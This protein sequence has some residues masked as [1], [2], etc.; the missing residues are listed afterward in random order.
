M[1]QRGFLGALRLP[2]RHGE[3]NGH[4]HE[5]RPFI[6]WVEG[7]EDV[8]LYLRDVWKYNFH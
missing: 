4:E 2:E 5:G 3:P 6:F 7:G 8:V 1:E